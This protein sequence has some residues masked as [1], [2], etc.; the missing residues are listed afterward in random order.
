MP[1]PSRASAAAARTADA[2]RRHRRR[3][4]GRRASRP[5]GGDGLERH[6]GRAAGWSSAAIVV[7]VA[8]RGVPDPAARRRSAA[9]GSCRRPAA[10]ASSGAPAAVVG[11]GN[12][13]TSQPAAAPGRPDADGHAEHRR[14]AR[15]SSRSRPTCRRSRPATSWRSPSCGFYDGTPFHRTPTLQDGTPFVIQGGDPTGTGTGGP[16]YTIK[17][18]PVTTTVQARHRRDGP[19][20]AAELASARSSSSSSTT[21]TRPS[22]PRRTP[23]RSSAT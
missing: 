2:G 11:H 7:V 23:T 22:S 20:R 9:P 12:C 5:V 6:P 17:D 8:R 18:E 15:S 16:G 13:P 14:R 19:V 21:R 4:A 3:R 1:E 10:A